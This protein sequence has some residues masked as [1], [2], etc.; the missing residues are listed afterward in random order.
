MDVDGTRR[1][2]DVVDHR[3]TDEVRPTR[4]AAGAEHDLRRVLVLGE[5]HQRRGGVGAG[6]L[7]VLTAELLQE[8]A[9]H[10]ERITRRAAQAVSGTAQDLAGN[11]ASTS[12]NAAPERELILVGDIN[13]AHKEIDL[14]NWKSNQK[15]SGFTP[16]ER[17]W[18]TKLTTDGGIIDDLIVYRLG[19]TRFL[20]V[21]NAGNALFGGAIA[22]VVAKAVGAP[23]CA[24]GECS[25][26]RRIRGPRRC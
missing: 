23:R 12:R 22:I 19:E 21:A 14:K 20:V 6:E 4:L 18:M 2:D 10:A 5:L 8:R 13:I 9:L 16:E 24:T 17:A 11:T 7:V 25:R 3:A 26:R 15:N 1:P